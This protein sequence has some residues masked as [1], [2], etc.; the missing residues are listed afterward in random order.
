MKL[1]G[2]LFVFVYI[3]CV[4]AW[5]LIKQKPKTQKPE[6]CNKPPFLGSCRPLSVQWYFDVTERLCK[7]LS[8]GFCSAGN[9]CFAKYEKCKELCE[10]TSKKA[11]PHMCQKPPAVIR[12]RHLKHAWFFDANSTSCKM[13]TFDAVTCGS[14]SN[15][16]Y[17]EMKCQSVC[18]PTKKP[19]PSCSEDTVR[20]ICVITRKHWFF[21][22]KTNLCLRF[23][24]NGCGKGANSFSTY[25]K[26]MQ[27]C[28]YIQSTVACLNCEQKY[29]NELPQQGKPTGPNVVGPVS[30]LVPTGPSSPLNP[31]IHQDKLS[32]KIPAGTPSISSTPSPGGKPSSALPGSTLS[33]HPMQSSQQIPTGIPVSPSSPISQSKPGMVLPPG[34]THPEQHKQPTPS[35]IPLTPTGTI[36]QGTNGSN[37]QPRNPA[38]PTNPTQSAAHPIPSVISGLPSTQITQRKPAL[39]PAVPSQPLRPFRHLAGFRR[40]HLL[41]HYLFHTHA[42]SLPDW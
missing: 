37:L 1:L 25:D 19:K 9:N 23:P 26:C 27:K 6:F 12:S 32:P 8:S 2:C 16:F 40:T 29:P 31:P 7:P 34:S 36:Q 28:S 3:T 42:C 30:P 10:T 35:G 15:S 39:A 24:R 21:D 5:S 4:C 17:T 18:I 33:T 22:Y 38:L 11:I 13:Y 20:D 14:T 41:H